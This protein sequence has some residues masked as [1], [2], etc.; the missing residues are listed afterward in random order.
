ME[1]YIAEELVT[2]DAEHPIWSR[3]F[4]VAPLVLIGTR[5][6]NQ[7]Y[8]LAPK[9]MAIPM[10]WDN[11]FGFV[12]TDTHTTYHNIRR[13]G[14]FTVTYPRPTQVVLASLSATKRD[15]D[16]F[17]P[18][19]LSLP[20]FQADHVDGPFVSDGYVYLE[21]T[22]DKII[23]GFGLNSLITGTIVA[24][25]VHPDALRQSEQNSG[26][27]LFEMP[28]L[29]YIEPGRFARISETFSFPFPRD[30]ER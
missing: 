13:E 30:F 2:L 3:F 15:D 7:E 12:C 29:A 16:S 27:L 17:K 21:C 23:D 8:N 1:S 5:D 10:G 11:Y 22:L 18:A 25:H 19:L 14:V 26:E 6:A 28:L 24:A 4:T 9:H 20:I